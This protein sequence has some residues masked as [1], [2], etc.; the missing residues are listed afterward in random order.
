MVSKFSMYSS[1]TSVIH[2]MLL[3]KCRQLEPLC[4]VLSTQLASLTTSV[5]INFVSLPLAEPNR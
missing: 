2:N 4:S 5:S 3:V 1:T